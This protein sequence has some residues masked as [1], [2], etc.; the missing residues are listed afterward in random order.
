MIKTL[1]LT[2]SLVFTSI[3]FSQSQITG[4]VVDKNNKA[5]PAATV[6]IANSA[7]KTIT[8]TKGAFLIENLSKGTYNI[9]VSL[10]GYE[11]QTKSVRVF[12]NQTTVQFSLK[13]A[14]EQLNS[15]VV[16]GNFS[17]KKQIESSTSSHVLTQKDLQET[18]AIGTA[19]L[20]SN[21]AGTFTDASAGEVFTK[22]YARGI[23]A[24]AED[25]LGWYYTSLQEDGLPVSLI[26]HSYYSPDLFYRTD[27][28]TSKLEAIT[29]GK[30]AIA[31]MNAPGGIYNFISQ[32]KREAFGGQI[33][34]T[35]GIQGNYNPYQ[36][37]E[38]ISNGALGNQWYYNI[39]GHLR[40]DDGARDT[41][42]TFSKGGQAKLNLIKET[43][44]GFFKF[45][46]KLLDDKTNRW[47]GVTA[48]NWNNPTPAY[49]QSFRHTSQLL[50]FF[51]ATVPQDQTT[52]NTFNPSQGVHAKDLAL[53]LN[54][55]QNI[56]NNW[57]LK[58]N[59]KYTTKSANWQ[60]TIS[61]AFVSLNN[62]LAYFITGA[63]FPIGKV[64][65]KDA[66][67]GQEL[68]QVNNSAILAGGEINYLTSGSLPNDALLGGAAWYKNT[69]AQEIMDRLILRKK[70]DQHDLN[71]G[72][73][74]G[75][76][77]TEHYTQSSFVFATY[78]NNP[79]NLSVTLENPGSPVIDLS[80][81][82]GVSNY[83]GLFFEKTTAQLQQLAFFFNDSWD[84]NNRLNLDLG[85]RYE[86]STHK[87]DRHSATPLNQA[88]GVDGNAQTDYDN[89]LLVASEGTN[90]FDYN[91]NFLSYSAGLNYVFQKN[92][93]A[94]VRYSRGNKAPEFDYYFNNF[95]N[96]SI[97]KKG[98]IQE[99]HQFE[100]GFKHQQEKAS[101]IATAFYSALQNIGTTNFEFDG[102]TNTVFYT[103]T[104][105]NN[106]KTIGLELETLYQPF[107]FLRFNLNG[108]LQ[109]AKAKDWTIY[110]ANGSVDASDDTTVSYNNNKLPFNPNLMFNLKTTFEKER[111]Y[112]YLNYKYMGE[113]YGNIANGF[114]LP[115][116]VTLDLGSGVKL[117]EKLTCSLTITNLLNSNGLNNFF[118][119]NSFGAN[120]NQATKDYVANNPDQAFIVV[121]INPRGIFT[122]LNYSF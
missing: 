104:Q 73:D 39:G 29:G 8:N 37:I 107:S 7:Q 74:L 55:E 103:P 49:G 38:F 92:A 41:D 16:T 1:F 64:V 95:S 87:G 34:L 82:N 118:G 25:D 12:N 75:Y 76:S 52:S 17:P 30:S 117:T 10:L 98:E 54:L 32:D 67:S 80:D 59:F 61:N 81:A 26:Q 43:K 3:A 89:G 40:K 19:D 33:Q 4:K 69:E 91:Y 2:F 110:D 5:L 115:S 93:A 106:S 108:L 31:A 122:K 85:F 60:T 83:G 11:S 114:K 13:L 9:T 27:L 15:V 23:S 66:Q 22:V 97:P 101:I 90:S 100:I 94:F 24:S 65:F 79:R 120:A 96:V 71:F 28:T 70:L 6:S 48:T 99:I 102:D 105:F 113:R 18:M 51:N 50:P 72:V 21:I 68:A 53:G 111:F 84:L 112:V 35:T 86:N 56:G 62:P 63:G 57:T 109:N 42:F 36:K 78:E 58:N 119:P 20:L 44:N 14:Y 88:G 46:A 45:Y 47:N 116:Y 121:P 77:D